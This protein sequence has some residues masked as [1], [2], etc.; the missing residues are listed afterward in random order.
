MCKSPFT[1]P[2]APKQTTMKMIGAVTQRTSGKLS[3][4]GLDP[5]NP[6]DGRDFGPP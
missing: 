2:D 1:L 4:M 6:V 3:I 5:E